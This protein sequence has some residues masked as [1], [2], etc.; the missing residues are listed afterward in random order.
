MFL[1]AYGVLPNT[2]FWKVNFYLSQLINL[3]TLFSQ[4]LMGFRC[5][6]YVL[7]NYL[8]RLDNPEYKVEHSSFVTKIMEESFGFSLRKSAVLTIIIIISAITLSGGYV[9]FF[10]STVIK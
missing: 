4:I 9:Y 2:G 10:V 1:T 7:E 3:S 6:L 8:R 5:P